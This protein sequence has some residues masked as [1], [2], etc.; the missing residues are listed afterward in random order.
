MSASAA[1]EGYPGKNIHLILPP[2]TLLDLS[3]PL[4]KYEVRRSIFNPALKRSLAIGVQTG[5]ISNIQKPI[6][7]DD[8]V[9][10]PE[11]FRDSRHFIRLVVDQVIKRIFQNIH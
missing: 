8:L 11:V 6:E 2:P 7:L 10:G 9:T 1:N 3:D 4:F 5:K